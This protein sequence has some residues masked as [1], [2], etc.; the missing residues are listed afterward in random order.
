MKRSKRKESG[1]DKFL[2][3][4]MEE[5]EQFRALFLAEVMKLPVSGQLRALRNL[6]G[7]SQVVL[8]K[9]TKLAQSEVARLE[10][11]GANPRAKT[12]ER[13]AKGLG[14]RVELIPEKLLPFLGAQQLRAEGE[15]YFNKIALPAEAVAA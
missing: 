7:L 2:S 5:D 4:S 6:R 12:L 9:R 14:A 3:E 10:G 8:S 11:A 1:L 13:I 15:A